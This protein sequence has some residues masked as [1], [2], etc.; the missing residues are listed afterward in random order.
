MFI[1]QRY[2]LRAH[3]A[4]FLFGTSVVMFLFLMQFVLKYIDQLVGKGLSAWVIIQLVSLN[5]AWMLVLAVPMGVLFSTLMAFGSMSASHEITIF[6]ASGAGL[7]RLMVPVIIAGAVL[8]YGMYVFNDTVLP[9]SNHQ[10]KILMWDIQKK[11]PTF[12]IEAGQF[13]TQLE[14]YTILSR[15]LDSLNGTMV[16]VT[17]YDRTTAGRTNVVSADSGTIRFTS[18]FNRV[19]VQLGKGEIHQ[20]FTVQ[21]ANY[22]Y[23]RFSSHQ[24]VIPASGFKLEQSGESMF[25]RGDREMCIADMRKIVDDAERQKRVASQAIDSISAKHLA[26]L[27]GN[28]NSTMVEAGTQGTTQEQVSGRLTL[29]RNQ[30]EPLSFQYDDNDRQVRKYLVEIYK[31]Y[32]IPVACFVF[33]FVGCPLGIVT[34][35]GNFG[36]SA[37]IS[38]GFYVVYWA[39]LIGGEKLADRQLSSPMAMWLANVVIGCIGLFLSLKLNNESFSLLAMFSSK[40]KTSDA[41]LQTANPSSSQILASTSDAAASDNHKA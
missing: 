36:I 9:D 21:P 34:K 2:T 27:F 28:E 22:R 5:L 19:V 20:V 40:N 41:V 17:I 24:I 6:K 12:D 4:P 7:L 39:C 23:I 25:A 30:I 33:I 16:G 32:A 15:A 10:A 14:G 31:K 8:T 18:D 3:V 35:G 13:S 37:A 38:L 1:V 26:Y 29:L 11:K